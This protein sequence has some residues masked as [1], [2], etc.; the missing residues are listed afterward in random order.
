MATKWQGDDALHPAFGMSHAGFRTLRESLGLSQGDVAE[1]CGVQE[2]TVRRWE[3]P[4]NYLAPD[5][6]W[7][8]LAR[9]RRTFESGITAALDQVSAITRE[10]GKPPR[11][12]SLT[13]YR[14]Q[15]QYDELGRDEGP[16][17]FRNAMTREVAAR[18]EERG[19]P[20][21]IAF[22]DE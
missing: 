8:Y 2:R 3:T 7:A 11:T 17:G 20:V 18:L 5:D 1:A 22:V 13:Y 19:L 6:A 9:M 15:A 4:G 12:V 16:V 21:R 10:A 14:N